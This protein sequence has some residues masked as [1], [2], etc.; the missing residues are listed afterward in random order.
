MISQFKIGFEPTKWSFPQRN[1]LLAQIVDMLFLPEAEQKSGSLITTEFV[2]QMGKMVYSVPAP[3]FNSSSAGVFEMMNQG[4]LT[5]ITDF[6]RFFDEKF[7]KSEV[8]LVKSQV[9]FDYFSCNQKRIL[10]LLQRRSE[11]GI[12]DLALEL[13]VSA[14]QLMQ[15][16]TFLE[17]E[18]V[19]I[20]LR[21]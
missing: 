2:Y 15:E 12:D 10:E 14:A 21:P 4:K 20:Q 6:E 1:K 16:L 19:I 5:L 3:L 18:D 7:V 9:S 13:G 8:D 17:I 11:V